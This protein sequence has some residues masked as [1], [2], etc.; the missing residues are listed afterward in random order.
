MLHAQLAQGIQPVAPG[1]HH[2]EDQQ[3]RPLGGVAQAHQRLRAIV[4][5][6][7]REPL[8]PQI[9]GQQAAQRAVVIGNQDAGSVGCLH[10][11][12]SIR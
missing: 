1:H 2:V 3:V 10:G 7:D 8:A 4:R 6:I 9:F 5:E 11:S 12:H